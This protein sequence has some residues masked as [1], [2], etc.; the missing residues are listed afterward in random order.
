MSETITNKS[1][2]QETLKD[3]PHS[4][5]W[6]DM[7][8]C[9]PK[10]LYDGGLALV[11]FVCDDGG[12]YLVL[13]RGDKA[14]CHYPFH[15]P[16]ITSLPKDPKAIPCSFEDW[17][18]ASRIASVLLTISASID[19]STTLHRLFPLPSTTPQVAPPPPPKGYIQVYHGP[20]LSTLEDFYGY[21]TLW[22][23]YETSGAI[24]LVSDGESWRAAS[25]RSFF[26]EDFFLMP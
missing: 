21:G 1:V 5:L 19:S 23:S 16:R 18:P 24:L 6:F 11:L 4:L 8:D 25:T 17:T 14:S 20:L 2:L 7:G 9:D 10:R 13:V 12:A 15:S 3:T 26:P 22:Y